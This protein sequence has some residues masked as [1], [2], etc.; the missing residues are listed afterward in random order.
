MRWFGPCGVARRCDALCRWLGLLLGRNIGTNDSTHGSPPLSGDPSV[1]AVW[2]KGVTAREG[3]VN[4]TE[5]I[6]PFG[7]ENVADSLRP[8]LFPPPGA[9]QR[10]VPS[11]PLVAVS[12]ERRTE[13]RW[14]MVVGFDSDFISEFP[15]MD[16]RFGASRERRAVA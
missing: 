6:T 14:R 13:E 12:G 7:M 3:F 8:A 4:A 16:R 1:P 15:L 2:S 10:P 9:A 5:G 11:G